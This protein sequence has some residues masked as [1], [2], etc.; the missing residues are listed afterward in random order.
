MKIYITSCEVHET[1]WRHQEYSLI[2]LWE[3]SS[4]VHTLTECPADADIII[5]SN[6]RTECNFRSL[7]NHPVIMRFPLKCYGIDEY[8]DWS[9]IPLLPGVYASARVDLPFANRYCSGSYELHHVNFKNP[10]IEDNNLRAYE[11]EKKHLA[12]FVGRRSHS[13]RDALFELQFSDTTIS[14]C[15]TSVFNVFTHEN[16]GKLEHQR[17]FMSTLASSKF[18]ICPRGAGASSVRL[19][20]VMKSGVA[21]V[22][23]SDSWILPLGP[24][25]SRFAIFVPE[26]EIEQLESLLLTHEANYAQ[27]GRHA[28]EA[29]QKYFATERY[30]DY[31]INQII[32]IR[33]RR[34]QT[35]QNMIWKLRHIIPQIYRVKR[36]IERRLKKREL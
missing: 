31:I 32:I 2:A 22:V 14:I 5:I 10:F 16:D 20:E 8:D 17:N 29:Y 3:L 9:M 28:E 4:K 27:M 23:L 19:F 26:N 15:D 6:L 33:Q 12:S 11:S 13:V 1:A 24:D 36:G 30:F 21:P 34:S 18:A 35:V 7:R 25:W